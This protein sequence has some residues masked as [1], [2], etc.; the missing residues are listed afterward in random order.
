MTGD[1]NK[2]CAVNR[3]AFGIRLTIILTLRTLSGH[4]E[5]TEGCEATE[6]L[7]RQGKLAR[8]I[9]PSE[10]PKTVTEMHRQENS[11]DDKTAIELFL[12]GVAG[13]EAGLRRQFQ[14]C[15]CMPY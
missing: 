15:E 8:V 12:G 10:R 2:R 9:E 6:S 4:C 5:A 13:W 14:S 1:R 11:R 3:R 7:C